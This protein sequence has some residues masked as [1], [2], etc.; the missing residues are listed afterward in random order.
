MRMRT[1]S[2]F[3]FP[4]RRTYSTEATLPTNLKLFHN[5][6]SDTVA[7]LTLPNSA[8]CF[9]KT[10][11]L[12]ASPSPGEDSKEPTTACLLW[13]HAKDAL[14]K[15]GFQPD[16]LSTASEP[17]MYNIG[18]SSVAGKG[19]FAARDIKR[20]ETIV[21]ERPFLLMPAD[22]APEAPQDVADLQVWPWDSFKPM[23]LEVSNVFVA[24]HL[25]E[26]EQEVLFGL[27]SIDQSLYATVSQ[28]A[29]I[30]LEPLPGCPDGM[31]TVVCRDISRINH[32]CIPNV[33]VSW[34]PKNLAVSIHA[35]HPIRAGAEL[36]FAYGVGNLQ[37]LPRAERR[38]R[39]SQQY[40]FDCTCPACSLSDKASAASDR[41]R[42]TLIANLLSIGEDFAQISGE[43]EVDPSVNRWLQD[44]TLPD[45]HV[46]A[47]S[48]RILQIMEDE[49]AGLLVLWIIHCHRLHQAYAALGDVERAKY[50]AARY[51]EFWELP[52]L[53]PTEAEEMR[54]LVERPEKAK[55]W[56]LRMKHAVE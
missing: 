31:Y 10:T 43:V 19:M 20:G 35:L 46:T 56:G 26:N 29:I 39:L 30:A 37:F 1:F 15:S 45:D 18:P 2:S 9:L 4:R 13:G 23:V 3:A 5:R 42:A 47:A 48:E 38:E 17:G 51:L 53:G 6:L 40:Y 21:V 50:W 32:S 34:N 22:Q 27:D 24:E 8:V 41:N 25:T 49:G 11:R 52:M 28:N 44:P 12:P 36:F 14:D 7:E 55:P 54:A 33:E 16:A